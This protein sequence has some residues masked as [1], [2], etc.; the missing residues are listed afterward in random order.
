MQQRTTS[1]ADTVTAQTN[2]THVTSFLSTTQGN[3]FS[4]TWRSCLCNFSD[5]I[6]L[7][8][9]F[10]KQIQESMTPQVDWCIA[11]W[12]MRLHYFA[13]LRWVIIPTMLQSGPEIPPIEIFLSYFQTNLSVAN[14]AISFISVMS[15]FKPN[16]ISCFDHCSC[17]IFHLY[18][19]TDQVTNRQFLQLHNQFA[20][21]SWSV[22]RE[23]YWK[24][25]A[26]IM[27]HMSHAIPCGSTYVYP[28]VPSNCWYTL[29]YSQQLTELFGSVDKMMGR[30]LAQQMMPQEWQHYSHSP[31]SQPSDVSN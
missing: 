9:L 8:L 6:W 18:V 1:T 11:T 14:N 19:S 16:R 27:S 2:K 7:R 31:S 5:T 17:P 21:V 13:V 30:P 3:S 10:P 22:E 26:L 23:L 29:P 20:A 25:S 24:R 15:D 28:T 12:Y 4:C